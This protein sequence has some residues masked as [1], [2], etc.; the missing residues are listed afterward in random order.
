[1][2]INYIHELIAQKLDG[3]GIRRLTLEVSASDQSCCSAT[4]ERAVLLYIRK[5][6]NKV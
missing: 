3:N 5:R 4:V 1:M 2:V 6:V